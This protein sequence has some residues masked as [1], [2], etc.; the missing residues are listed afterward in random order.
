MG[1][2]HL[3]EL[4][5][6]RLTI[7]KQGHF[8]VLQAQP[9]QCFGM[10]LFDHQGHQGRPDGYNGMPKGFGQAVAVTCGTRPR[11][12]GS[13][14]SYDHR[15]GG[16]KLSLLRPYPCYPSALS[17]QLLYPGLESNAGTVPAQVIRQSVSYLMS[18]VGGRKDPLPPFH[19]SR[20]TL[21]GEEINE[22]LVE[23][24]SE[25]VA[26]KDAVGAKVG[27]KVR[28]VSGVGQ[29]ATPLAGDAQLVA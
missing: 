12:G 3:T 26:Q 1:E 23:K 8:D 21:G 19:H 29:V 25:G 5:G 2:E 11:I 18:I 15:F 13:T 14:G 20:H 7:Q 10:A 24:A 28:R 4:A 22:I 17:F 6:D 16:Q 27:D 9:L